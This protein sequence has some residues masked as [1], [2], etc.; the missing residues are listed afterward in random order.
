LTVLFQNV[1]LSFVQELEVYKQF[2]VRFSGEE[3]GEARQVFVSFM[4]D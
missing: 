1:F 4:V 3:R 2:V